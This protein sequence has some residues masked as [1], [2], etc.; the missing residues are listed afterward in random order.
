[1]LEVPGGTVSG[2]VDAH[3]HLCADG[4]D[5]ALDRIGEPGKEP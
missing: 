4:T 2:L 5:G 1:V 3:V